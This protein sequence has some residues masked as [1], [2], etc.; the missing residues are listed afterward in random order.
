M[1]AAEFSR[2]IKENALGRVATDPA[3]L[4]VAFCS[5]KARLKELSALKRRDWAPEAMVAGGLAAYLWCA[6]G[7]L[8]SRLLEAVGRVLGESTTT[9]NWATVSKVHAALQGESPMTAREP[10]LRPTRG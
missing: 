1:T 3:R 10:P 4:L 9:R 8:A 6:D 7:I 2:V 5:D